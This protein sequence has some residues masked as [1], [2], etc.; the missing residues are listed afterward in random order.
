ML[1]VR[2]TL[3]CAGMG[4]AASFAAAQEAPRVETGAPPA[5][6]VEISRLAAGTAVE[7]AFVDALSSKT[8]KIDDWFAVR[9]TKPVSIGD[10]LVLPVGTPGKGQ[11]VH[12]A[13]AGGGGKAGELIVTVRYLDVAG[14]RVPLRRFRMGSLD[15]GADRR[16][17]AL[18]VGLVV[19]FGGFLV[20]GGEKTIAAGALGNAIVA[21]AAP[22]PSTQSPAEGPENR[23]N[24]Q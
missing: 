14:Q 8:S 4:L 23:G 3:A 5:Q 17:E 15:I 7:F 10:T 2:A 11:V 24:V 18:G 19:P 16:D 9:L 22:A 21:G 6:T 20:R 13:K 1:V 12:A